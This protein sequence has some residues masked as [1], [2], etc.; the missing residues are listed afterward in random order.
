MKNT[1]T[2]KEYRRL[3]NWF[4]SDDVGASSESIVIHMLGLSSMKNIPPSDKWDRA[5][6]SKLLELIPKWKGRIKEMEVYQGWKEQIP[7]IIL[8]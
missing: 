1:L 3:L 7:L 5:R 4:V 2:I 6:C 8:K